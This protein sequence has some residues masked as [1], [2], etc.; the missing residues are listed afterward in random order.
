MRLLHQV[1]LSVS[2]LYL[3][4]QHVRANLVSLLLL[5]TCTSYN[6]STWYG[7]CLPFFRHM[8]NP[9]KHPTSISAYRLRGKNSVS[10][11]V[12]VAEPAHSEV[13]CYLLHTPR[14]SYS[15]FPHFKP[16][17]SSLRVLSRIL[18]RDKEG[19]EKVPKEEKPPKVKK[20]RKPSGNTDG[21]V[22]SD[23]GADASEQAEDS[24]KDKGGKG[25]KGDQSGTLYSYIQLATALY[26]L[27]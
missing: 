3:A 18:G 21:D 8:Y 26:I 2:L 17:V 23:Q 10:T 6:I 7:V 16:E 13:N 11:S 9:Q 27:L 12:V 20:G 24:G 25:K 22:T 1:S 14:A 15:Q 5:H 4:A 19:E